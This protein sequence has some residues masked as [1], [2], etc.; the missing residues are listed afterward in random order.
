MKPGGVGEWLGLDWD[1]PWPEPLP[2]PNL[3]PVSGSPPLAKASWLYYVTESLVDE[4]D[5]QPS[6]RHQTPAELGRP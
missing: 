2:V 3:P 6:C 4:G 5:G 1:R